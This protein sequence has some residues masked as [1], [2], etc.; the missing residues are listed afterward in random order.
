MTELQLVEPVENSL[1][2]DIGG[3]MTLV[4]VGDNAAVITWYLD[5]ELVSLSND[6]PADEIDFDRDLDTN[7][8]TAR[9]TRRLMT[10]QDGGRYECRDQTRHLGDSRPV[11]VLI[12]SISQLSSGCRQCSSVIAADRHFLLAFFVA[13]LR[14]L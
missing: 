8:Q 12:A 5:S 4:C 6:R 14:T 2:M 7:R 3:N 13:V 9:L 11:D 10:S 1:A